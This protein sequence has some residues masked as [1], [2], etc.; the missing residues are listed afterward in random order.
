MM[1]QLEEKTHVLLMTVSVLAII[2][3][4]VRDYKRRDAAA[5]AQGLV[6]L[7]RYQ[8]RKIRR[9]A[10]NHGSTYKPRRRAYGTASPLPPPFNRKS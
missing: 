4:F 10:N 8:L 9:A 2:G 5:R 6:P 3:F 1:L 7:S